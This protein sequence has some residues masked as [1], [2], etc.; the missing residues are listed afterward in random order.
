MTSLMTEL[1][2]ASQIG[3]HSTRMSGQVP[4]AM[5]WSTA[6]STSTANSFGHRVSWS[7]GAQ[8]ALKWRTSSWA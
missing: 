4:V 7:R 1:L 5:S 2:S 6:R 3:P 8:P